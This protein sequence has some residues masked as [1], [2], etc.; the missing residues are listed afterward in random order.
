MFDNFSGGRSGQ[1][2][3]RFA[4]DFDAMDVM[5][6]GGGSGPSSPFGGIASYQ[7]CGCCARF[8]G[9]TDGTDGGGGLAALLNADD[10]GVFGPNGKPSL[11]TG[12]AGGQI[13]RS[14]TS[15]ATSLGTAA[16][17]T[18]AFR[19]SATTMPTDTLDFSQ[20]NATQ[21]SGALQAFSAWSD[22]ANITFQRVQDAGSQ[23]SNGA[24]ILLGNYGSG[25]EGAAA[26]AYLPAGMP[27]QS[28]FAS[29]A[30]DVWINSS[31][32]YNQMPVQQGYGQ[33]TLLH[34][35]GHAIGLS[36]PAAYNASAD[37]NITY[38]GSATYFED[39][40]QY[41]VMSYFSETNT[42][43]DFRTNGAGTSRYA[44]AP[45]MD[46]IAAAQRLY[47]ANTTTRTGDTTYGFNSN[48]GQPWFNANQAS[49]PLIFCVWDAGGTDTLD[50]SGF[51]QASTI[52]L[53]QG[54]FSSV[55]G[56]VGNVSIAIGAVIENVV[57]GT[58]GDLIRG[59]SGDN[60]I[61]G[62]GGNDTIDGGLGSDTVVF[63][64]T[65]ASYLVEW[66]GQ[67]GVVAGSGG[68]VSL[69]NVEFLQFSDQ[70]IA[71]TPTGGLVVGGDITN[72]TIS[73][74]GFAD[75]LGGLGG[76][77]TVNGLGGNDILDGGSGNDTL[78]GGDG[79]DVL[80]GGLGADTLN[81]GLG[82]DTADYSGA[83][84]A[85]TVDLAAGAASG[86]AGSDTLTQV[87]NVTGSAYA[88]ILAGDGAAN[89]LRGGGGIDT[90]SGGGGADQLY[91]GAPG[92]TGGAPDIVKAQGT[93][94]ASIGAAVSLAGGFDLLSQANIANSTTIP[95][96]TVVATTHGGVEYYAVTVIAGDTVLFDIDGASFDS[97]LRLFDAAG[98]E[99]ARNDDNAGDGGSATDSSLTHT[100]AA[101]GTYYIQVAE[102]ATNTA[103]SFTSTAPTA[104]GSYTLHVSVPSATPVPL[105]LV[106]STLN[107]DGGA[108]RLEGGAG[109][110]TLNGGADD[111]TLIGAGGADV[112][113]GGAGQ[114]T[115]VY[116]GNRASYTVSVSGGVTTVTGP[117]G[118]DTLTNVERI[119]FA[120]ALTDA[121]GA[122][123]GGEINGTA[124]G[125]TLTGDAGANTINGLGGD[126]IITGA[127]G[128]DTIDGGA[129]V[130]TAVFSGVRAGYTVS[131][132]GGVTTVTGP[133]GVDT[134]TTVERLR[135][136]D[137]TLLVG[138]G[139][140]QYVEGTAAGETLTGTAFADEILGAGGND[141]ISGLAGNDL[142]RGGDGNDTINAGTGVDTVFGDSGDDTFIVTSVTA[143]QAP[144]AFDGGAGTD[145]FDAS[146]VAVA[147]SFNGAVTNGQF[148]VA[149]NTVVG[150]ERVIGGS[151]GDTLAF[152]AFT[153]ALDLLGGGGDDTLQGG[154]G[155]DRLYG[156]LGAD[157]LTGLAGDQLYGEGGDDTLIFTGSAVATAALIAGG[158]GV[159]TAILRGDSASIDLASGTGTVGA[160]SV[161]I[162]TTENVT[163][164]GAGAGTRT[165]LGNGAANRLSAVG[166]AFG[167]VFEGRSGD[168]TLLGGT[169]AD[170]LDGGDGDDFLRGGAGNDTLI[171]GAGTDLADYS[172][173]AGAVTASLTLGGAS[174]DGDGGVDGFSGIENLIGS[175]FGDSLT[176]SGGANVLSGGAGNDTL[177]GLAGDD[178]ILSG[179]GNDVLDGGS[180]VDL[181]DYSGAASGVRVQLNTGTASND[182][183]G[184]SDTIAG[185]E[186]LTGST[187]GDLLVGDGAANIIRGGLGSDTLIAGAGNDTL[188]GGSGA[189]NEMY[190]GAGD[191]LFILDANDTVVEFA[192]EGVDTVE[193]RIAVYNLGANLE[194]LVY[195]GA[196]NFTGTGNGAN[197]T[198]IGGA[199]HDVLRGRGGDDELVGG[200]G[201]DTADYTQA[202]SAVLV[203]L[204]SL[205][206]LNDGE[207]GRDF[208]TSIENITGSQFNDVV[209]GNSSANTLIGG[210][211][212]DVLLGGAGDDVI[213]GG[214]IQQNELHG[215]QGN[216]YYVL[217]VADTVIEYAGEGVDTVESRVSTYTLAA[218][219]E[220]LIYTGP[221]SFSGWG[222]G[223]DNR[224]T[225]GVAD[226]YLRGMGGNDTIDGGAGN[227]ILYLRGVAAN[228]T[229]TAE[230]AGW[231]I[232]DGV[233]GRDGS[234]FV[235]SVEALMFADNTTR[236]LDY[237]PAS[238]PEPGAGKE[239]V[240]AALVSPRLEDDDLLVLPQAGPDKADDGPTVLPWITDDFLF[241]GG[242]HDGPMVQPVL[243]DD[244]GPWVQPVL[245]A[246]T[247]VQ[248]MLDELE[249][250]PLI[251]H[252]PDGLYL[253]QDASDPGP[254]DPWG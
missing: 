73:G 241:K 196:G 221:A 27:G 90:I 9:A 176:G 132:V 179:Q 76:I 252:G 149:D 4:E 243:A 192:G 235:T 3:A 123:V 135:F 125:D 89:V 162:Y 148:T 92:Q 15:W 168:D 223:L 86:A 190:G 21:I 39:S 29:S 206:T 174:N 31:L 178:I 218:N 115:A 87:E 232:I 121:A 234:T 17:V 182:G 5:G 137:V 153:T 50:F 144:S 156:G 96:A 55:G 251:V 197:N 35:I 134:L 183:D 53:R 82:Q 128:N 189:G 131:T 215:G 113:D 117:D 172:G 32:S 34:E 187:F 57:G 51:V 230:G 208:L 41:S 204:D 43:A 193:V 161:S 105:D 213:M 62:N 97:T 138:A 42:G 157:Q 59:N 47:G 155:A 245:P 37:G 244:A 163:L 159:D 228:Y 100:F 108:D 158:D 122:P 253:R 236:V 145:T 44:S 233:A 165:V 200:A 170:R 33:H 19:A 36:H 142:I 167:V 111:D 219:V 143:G 83:G 68:S 220:N 195:T 199:G 104:G 48:A 247:L 118:V 212:S 20:F 12:D 227:D 64:G 154:S 10:R 63:S 185:F 110:D 2:S 202:T 186:N 24:T 205:I 107:G 211:G 136:D 77:D 126:D 66:Y 224:I 99:L 6:G 237:A 71:A 150:V 56:L 67:N 93:A 217:D 26:F 248:F 146:A 231:R 166:A 175:A 80:I 112:L 46:D 1:G 54:A 177:L 91:A 127:G 160:T 38:S 84:A 194:R 226:D 181:L 8:H 25:Q 88:D 225:G 49:S 45:M 133:D 69:N 75:T 171:G 18:F 70:T 16:T 207:G 214:E 140:G 120:D 180:G 242:E 191:D 40:R 152:Q 58:G 238:P 198:L 106:G 28:A 119:Q 7:V 101:G 78:N 14:N 114:D 30:G 98:N 229:I 240:G 102:W 249:A 147:M 139:G 74:T 72:E 60:R 250:N 65:R 246:R 13:T 109:R 203:R 141:T 222:N 61:V 210:Q 151:A 184:G 169:A 22:V 129:G 164:E 11:S 103:D 173:A 95:H 94:N 124:A 116:A 239:D 130:D 79:D 201:L 52:D 23:Y 85:V 216:D 188:Y 81:G 209:V 254:V